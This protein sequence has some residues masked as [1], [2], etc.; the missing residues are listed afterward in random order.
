[1]KKDSFKKYA[2]LFSFIII[3]IAVFFLHHSSNTKV[4]FLNDKISEKSLSPFLFRQEVKYYDINFNTSYNTRH[5]KI[6]L[7][8]W[9][10]HLEDKIKVDTLEYFLFNENAEKKIQ[11]I[12]NLNQHKKKSHLKFDETSNFFEFI[13]FAKKI[14]K[15]SVSSKYSWNYNNVDFPLVNN[16]VINQ[17]LLKYE[18]LEDQFLRNRY[19]FQIIKAYFY[20]QQKE[21]LLSFF[22]KT[23]NS[24]P[25]NALY[26]RALSYCAG[27]YKQQNN[28][29]KANYI[30]SVIYE[31]NIDSRAE[32]ANN[33]YIKDN[34]S[35]YESLLFTKNN[36]E[37]I[38]LWSLYGFRAD[39]KIAI[40][41]IYKLNPKSPHLDYL[42]PKLINEEET[43]LNSL[44]IT[45]ILLNINTTK[46]NVDMDLVSLVNQISI[47][48]KIANPDLWKIASAYLSI[49]YDASIANSKLEVL[50][51]TGHNDE[52]RA[53][54]LLCKIA[55]LRKQASSYKIIYPE[56]D[57]LYKT[58]TESELYNLK[59]IQDY[60]LIH[61]NY[62][63][64]IGQKTK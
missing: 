49:F 57:W 47:E 38:A 32:I 51:N 61:M 24:E 23:K 2:I 42:L 43:R 29:A 50:K 64:N 52:I 20:S 21:N 63:N 9:N 6:I 17:L 44:V 35:F 31:N 8:E 56:L 45:P 27:I 12:Y 34:K 58:K 28:Q 46:A 5:N 25:K 22:E 59:D 26:Y 13:Y 1:M 53:L 54:K 10:K 7:T 18:T 14:E 48:E 15:S 11:E 55:K 30:Y 40:E 60:C 36:N 33:F 41:E 16:D 37:K 62:I 39:K 4:P 19:W 3:I